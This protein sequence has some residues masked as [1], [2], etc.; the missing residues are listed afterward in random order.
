MMASVLTGGM[1]A[2]SSTA[3]AHI[4]AQAQSDQLRQQLLQKQ[5]AAAAQS[6]QLSKTQMVQMFATLD[7]LSAVKLPNRPG[8]EESPK[9]IATL[10]LVKI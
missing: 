4:T 6:M 3:S 8:V 2:S 1:A 10:S 9:Y 5:S 7:Q